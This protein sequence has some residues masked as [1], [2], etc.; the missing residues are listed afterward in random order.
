MSMVRCQVFFKKNKPRVKLIQ[1]GIVFVILFGLVDD[2]DGETGV[3][4]A[5]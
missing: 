5:S 2:G 4:W 1:A 3:M